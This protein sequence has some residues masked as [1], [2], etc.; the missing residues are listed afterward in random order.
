MVA[1]LSFFIIWGRLRQNRWYIRVIVPM[2]STGFTGCWIW[3]LLG[4]LVTIQFI[5]VW[6]LLVV[7]VFLARP[8][9][10]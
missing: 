10:A 4:D 3:L 9:S 7:W 8:P 6:M 5:C 2:K 1:T